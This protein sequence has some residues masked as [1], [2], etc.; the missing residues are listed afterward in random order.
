MPPAASLKIKSRTV[1]ETRS[2]R[3]L[4]PVKQKGFSRW[5]QNASRFRYR[6]RVL[7]GA[8]SPA[9]ISP[10]S[11]GTAVASGRS[12]LFPSCRE[13]ARS[14]LSVCLPGHLRSQYGGSSPRAVPAAQPSPATIRGRKEQKGAHQTS[15]ACPP[16]LT[17]KFAGSRSG[18]IGRPLPTVG[19]DPSRSLPFLEVGRTFG[20]SRIYEPK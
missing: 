11:A 13:P 10:N 8:T 9:V 17:G 14:G 4:N 18:R 7:T 16:G 2:S 3:R 15:L 1:G 5:R 12:C 19:L 20:S 6:R